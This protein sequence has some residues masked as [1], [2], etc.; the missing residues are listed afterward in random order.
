LPITARSTGHWDNDTG[1]SGHDTHSTAHKMEFPK[2]DDADDPLLWLNR[3]ERFCHVRRTPDDKK[4]AFYLLNDAQL[5]FHRMELNG[6]RPTWPQ[7]VQLI[8]ALFG[9]PLTDSPI[10]ELAM[11]RRSGTVDEFCKHFIALS[12]RD[13]SL[14]EQQ[15]IQLFITDLGNPLWM[16]VALQ[17]PASFDNAI[18]FARAY[19]QCNHRP[20]SRAAPHSSRCHPRRPP[21]HLL[22]RLRQHLPQSINRH[23][24]LSDCLR[25]ILPNAGKV[26]NVFVVMNSSLMATRQSASSSSPSRWS[27]T[28]STI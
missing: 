15:Q 14:I 18:I 20:G 10:G 27:M 7:F 25:P 13:I 3:C 5:W 8:N 4:V 26:V 12:Y 1:D 21:C 23:R 17:Q 2:F 28:T 16:D 11:L 22:R 9:P 6:G 24:A 19:E